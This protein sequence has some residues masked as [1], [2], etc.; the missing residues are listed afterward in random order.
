MFRKVFI[1]K[2]YYVLFYIYKDVFKFKK[3]RNNDLN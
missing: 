2:I 3:Y 1:K